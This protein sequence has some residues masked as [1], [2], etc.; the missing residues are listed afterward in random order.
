MLLVKSDLTDW[1]N[2]KQKFLTITLTLSILTIFF[3]CDYACALSNDSINFYAFEWASTSLDVS[4]I[5]VDIYWAESGGNTFVFLDATLANGIYV[6]VGLRDQDGVKKA[7]MSVFQPDIPAIP[8]PGF[9]AQNGLEGDTYSIGDYPFNLGEYYRLILDANGESV[10]AY[11]YRHSTSNLT[12]IC[13]FYTG[14]NSTFRGYSWNSVSLEHYGMVDPS[15]YKSR[16]YVSSPM[17]MNV[18]GTKIGASGGYVNY[19]TYYNKSDVDS[20][21][22]GH[23]IISHGG[24]TVNDGDPSDN[25]YIGWS[26]ATPDPIIIPEFSSII[27]LST[28]IVAT[29]AVII[30]K[31]DQQKRRHTSV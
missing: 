25:G 26:S 1:S 4:R 16:I 7:S 28:L 8:G 18:N 15:L 14:V 10:S 5:G 22:I 3:S 12:N 29:L 23:I 9:T 30:I 6:T 13:K 17:R 27:M 21:G 11:V 24:D 2:K 20:D 31:K 19:Q